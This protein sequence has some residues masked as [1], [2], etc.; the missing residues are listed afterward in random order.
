GLAGELVAKLSIRCTGI[1]QPT[2]TL[3]GG[4]Q[5]KV[6]IGKWLATRPR[7]LLLD[8]PTRGIDVGAKRDIY[9][10]IF[11]LAADGLGIVVVTSELPELL[12]LADRILVMCEGE[13]TGLLPRR[14]ATQEA[15]MRLAT[16]RGHG[17]AGRV[18]A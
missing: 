15:V 11:A 4:N 5:Q 10:L 17:G 18:V 13:A 9:D 7:V 8:E 3:S 2:A 14:A 1:E 12:L 6:V 16:P